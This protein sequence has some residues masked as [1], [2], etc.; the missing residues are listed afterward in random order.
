MT[1]K[2]YAFLSRAQ[3]VQRMPTSI[4]LAFSPKAVHSLLMGKTLDHKLDCKS[5][6]TIYLE[7][8]E[9][10]EEDELVACST[11]GTGI[12]T[13]RDLKADYLR[14]AIETEGVFDLHDGQFEVKAT[15]IKPL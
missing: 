5:C 15:G 9:G 12:G 10:I 14:Q 3:W 6:G 2:L 1:A 8:P 11:C 13:W 4:G 7:I